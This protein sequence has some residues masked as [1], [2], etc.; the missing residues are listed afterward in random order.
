MTKKGPKIPEGPLPEKL[1]DIT[2]SVPTGDQIS[3]TKHALTGREEMI[4]RM[5]AGA[6][7]EP[8]E[9]LA[10]KAGA[11]AEALKTIAQLEDQALESHA[12][13]EAVLEEAGMPGLPGRGEAAN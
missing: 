10:D 12:Q 5:G 7:L 8:H 4:V 2:G 9:E 1:R 6:G 13:I 11:N 3:E